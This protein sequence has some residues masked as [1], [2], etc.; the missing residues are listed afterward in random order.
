[1]ERVPVGYFSKKISPKLPICTLQ[2]SIR[3]LNNT[4]LK[5]MSNEHT[6]STKTFDAGSWIASNYASLPSE[7]WVA[8]CE[9]GMVGHHAD[10]EKLT[11]ELE[12]KH[13]AINSVTFAFIE[14]QGPNLVRQ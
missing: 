10:L 11:A 9:S 13:I 7:E 5:L 6:P 8:V 14:A 4:N 12:E 2:L 1:M 3:A